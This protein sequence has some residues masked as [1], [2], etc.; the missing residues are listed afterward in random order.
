MR[1]R[2]GEKE[3]RRGGEE[4]RGEEERKRHTTHGLMSAGCGKRAF[5]SL[6]VC[7]A[8]EKS[9]LS[10]QSSFD[11]NIVPSSNS[12]LSIK[13]KTNRDGEEEEKEMKGGGRRRE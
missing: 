12:F 10:T 3:R 5:T 9:E 7:I 6:A 11:C 1:R 2:G 4:E 13:N 8:L